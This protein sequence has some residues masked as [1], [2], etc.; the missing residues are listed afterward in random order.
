[1][2]VDK[3]GIVCWVVVFGM[4]CVCWWIIIMGVGVGRGGTVLIFID[5]NISYVEVGI[6]HQSQVR[7]GYPHQGIQN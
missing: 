1:M 6:R 7:P 4:R 2:F 5:K 3:D